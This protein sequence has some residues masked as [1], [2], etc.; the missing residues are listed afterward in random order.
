MWK[1]LAEPN[2]KKRLM[3]AE[4]DSEVRCRRADDPGLSRA[5]ELLP[6]GVVLK[7]W[8]SNCSEGPVAAPEQELGTVVG[9]VE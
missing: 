3:R 7:G 8:I 2:R 5:E 1:H 4:I 6:W 9:Q